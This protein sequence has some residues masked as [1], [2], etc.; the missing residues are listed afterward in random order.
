MSDTTTNGGAIS[1]RHFLTGAGLVAGSVGLAGA[2]GARA[3]ESELSMPGE[4]PEVSMV[5]QVNRD[6][7]DYYGHILFSMGEIL[8]QTA[9]NAALTAVCFGPGLNLLRA[10]RPASVSAENHDRIASLMTYG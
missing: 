10:Q 6:D 2:A 9:N 5:Y 4:D 8:R 1:R 3:S 7:P